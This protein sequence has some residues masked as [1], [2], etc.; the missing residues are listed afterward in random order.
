[1]H[2]ERAFEAHERHLWNLSYRMT[3]SAA[4]ADDVVQEAFVRALERPPSFEEPVRPWL[5]RVVLNLSRDRLRR[6]RRSAYPGTWLPAPVEAESIDTSSPGARYDLYES[7]SFAFLLALERLTPNRR[8]VVLLRD[9]FDYSVAETASILGTS[10]G[11]VKTTLHRA[12]TDLDQLELDRLDLSRERREFARVALRKW[13]AA[14]ASLD[15]EAIERCLT[16]D[17]QSFSDGGGD[18]F[19]SRKPLLGRTKV[20][21]FH[22]TLR[23][24]LRSERFEEQ[25]EI[26]GRPAVITRLPQARSRNA[27]V[28]VL[29]CDIDRDGR[30]AALY[31][32]TAKE[33]VLRL[34]VPRNARSRAT[35]SRRRTR[36]ASRRS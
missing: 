32:I 18:Y 1:V 19:A 7:A 26:N 11:S 9:V 24:K 8:A 17:V 34:T 36:S 2:L 35:T 6:R 16:A 31:S 23:R 13:L 27:P 29:L 5:A 22:L 3:G 20:A 25:T 21:H 28:V 14:L 12:R 15:R 10:E 30:I 4:D 33:K